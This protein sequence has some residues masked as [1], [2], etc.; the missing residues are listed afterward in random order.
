MN[1]ALVGVRI[2]RAQQAL[3]GLAREAVLR[4]PVAHTGG[5]Y[6]TLDAPATLTPR[7]KPPHHKTIN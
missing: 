2:R 4:S 1:H 3:G 7:Q 5:T 6:P